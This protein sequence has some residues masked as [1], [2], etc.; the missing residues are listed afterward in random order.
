M[1]QAD[2]SV[3][4]A[5]SV[6]TY[7]PDLSDEWSHEYGVIFKAVED[8]WLKT[9]DQAYFDYIKSNIEPGIGE[10]GS[11]RGYHLDDY[12]LDHSNTGRLFFSLYEETGEERYR[13]AA[14]TLRDQYRSHP[15]T[16]EG[17]FW[18]KQVLPYQI[19]L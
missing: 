12:S 6:M 11:I 18:H 19:F 17:A 14:F 10:D 1:E 4:M 7:F 13:K 15:R 3:R 2:W 5:R 9:K 16:T 8:V